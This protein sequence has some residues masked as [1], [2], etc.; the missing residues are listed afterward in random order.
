MRSNESAPFGTDSQ[1]CLASFLA[2][3]YWPV[4]R[5]IVSEGAK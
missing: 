5:V 3:H 2:R 1:D 4:T